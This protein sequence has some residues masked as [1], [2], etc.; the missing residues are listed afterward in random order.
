MHA[1]REWVSYSGPARSYVLQT[2]HFPTLMGCLG[3]RVLQKVEEDRVR[4]ED[5]V[6][7]LRLQDLGAR[8]LC[9]GWGGRREGE[10]NV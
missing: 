5:V 1:S 3:D 2:P 10:T 6:R 7:R 8:T 9:W 4:A